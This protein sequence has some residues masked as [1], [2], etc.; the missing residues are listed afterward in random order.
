MTFKNITIAWMG[1]STIALSFLLYR[2]LSERKTGYVE[3]NKLFTG[4]DMTKEVNKQLEA[5]YTG[6]QVTMDSLYYEINAQ[7]QETDG[8]GLQAKKNR[9]NEIRHEFESNKEAEYE[10]QRTQVLDRLNEY[11]KLFGEENGYAVI[12][13]ANGSGSLMYSEKN[14]DV[15]DE[16][17]EFIN[18]KYKGK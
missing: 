3:I 10:K 13:G 5:K 9:Y 1:L 7:S 14:C 15:T 2:N 8:A 16:A 4:F 17:L 12:L 18:A 11:V 6:Q